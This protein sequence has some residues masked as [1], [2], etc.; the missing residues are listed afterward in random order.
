MLDDRFDPTLLG[1]KYW[2]RGNFT[3]EPCGTSVLLFD[4]LDGTVKLVLLDN[5]IGDNYANMELNV[6]VN[7]IRA[8]RLG[9]PELKTTRHLLEYVSECKILNPIMP[10][11]K[12]W[13][14][15]KHRQLMIDEILEDL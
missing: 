2:Y 13:V 8:M 1:F 10:V 15:T 3:N 12:D 14:R 7:G 11:L 9:L 6:F 5:Y 4:S